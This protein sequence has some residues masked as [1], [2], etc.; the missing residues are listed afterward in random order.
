MKTS[1]IK[2]TIAVMA[3]LLSFQTVSAQLDSL[4]GWRKTTVSGNKGT[5]TYRCLK[6]PREDHALYSNTNYDWDKISKEYPPNEYLTQTFPGY[7]TD[8]HN[9]FLTAVRVCFNKERIKSLASRNE[10]FYAGFKL[11]QD[12][13]IIY[14]HFTLDT[15]TV[16]T[17]DELYC[18]EENFKKL[19]VFVPIR[20][21]NEKH[22]DGFG[23]TTTFKE[24]Q[25][26]EIPA[27]RR[28]EE[29]QKKKEQWE[30]RQHR[31]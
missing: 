27:I 17:P 21:I 4:L 3:V 24:I 19:L 11:D 14:I 2:I 8:I 18:L 28:E 9:S 30:A 26:G 23:I 15:N 20:K 13:N 1:K 10:Q 25:A 29:R 12:G 22:M 31:N 6:N 5:T 16:I 7:K